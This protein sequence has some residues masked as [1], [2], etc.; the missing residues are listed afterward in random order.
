MSKETILSV[1]NLHVDFKTYAGDVKAIRDI[2]FELKKVK[3]LLSLVNQVLG[4]L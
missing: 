2:N 1:N 4:N 3:R